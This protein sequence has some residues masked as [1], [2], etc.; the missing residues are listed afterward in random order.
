MY[1][2]EITYNENMHG[3]TQN[4]LRAKIIFFP[5]QNFLSY[6]LL[7]AIIDGVHTVDRFICT[8][9]RIILW[10]VY[11][12]ICCIYHLLCHFYHSACP[13]YIQYLVFIIL[14]IP[15]VYVLSTLSPPPLHCPN[16]PGSLS[17]FLS[18]F[19]LSL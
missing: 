16:T 19:S 10:P 15:V 11:H 13:L 17:L 2:Y 8:V 1:N 14:N 4:L 12:S 6:L 18:F 5:T 3:N 9:Y 7:S